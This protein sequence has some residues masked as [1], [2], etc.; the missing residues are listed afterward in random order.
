MTAPVLDWVELNEAFAIAIDRTGLRRG[1]QMEIVE[2]AMIGA[3]HYGDIRSRSCRRP[4]HEDPSNNDK[5]KNQ[6]K[7][8]WF[9]LES[10]PLS[11]RGN[12]DEEIEINHEDLLRWLERTPAAKPGA[13]RGPKGRWR[14][15]DFWIEVVAVAHRPDG[16]DQM[17]RADLIRHMSSWFAI[18]NDGDSP[19]DSEIKKRV[20]QLYKRLG[21]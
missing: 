9:G 2:R 21:L 12:D 13:K 20:S 17:S 1:D 6:D 7:D 10:L 14:W 3:L 15:E 4:K 16:F 19:V 18:E 11:S 8:F 5:W